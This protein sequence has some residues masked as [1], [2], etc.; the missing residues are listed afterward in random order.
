MNI[1]LLF[2]L[3]KDTIPFIIRSRFSVP[4]GMT[5]SELQIAAGVLFTILLIIFFLPWFYRK[6]KPKNI[7]R[8]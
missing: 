7:T 5:K 4:E 3:I 8:E 2:Y 1:T 6:L